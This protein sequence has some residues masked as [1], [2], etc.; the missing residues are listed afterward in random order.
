M[1]RW[2]P[3]AMTSMRLSTGARLHWCV[4]WR[5]G[6]NSLG[7]GA[8]LQASRSRE[9]AQRLSEHWLSCLWPGRAIRKQ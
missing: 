7:A 9:L 2:E 3:Q 1:P 6:Q 8:R 4:A 5:A